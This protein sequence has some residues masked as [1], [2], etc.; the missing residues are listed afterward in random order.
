M[1]CGGDAREAWVWAWTSVEDAGRSG[2]T[3]ASYRCEGGAGW[4][5]DER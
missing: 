1:V 4:N 2:S 5:A 3:R